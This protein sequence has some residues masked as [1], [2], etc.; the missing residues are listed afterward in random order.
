[1]ADP[2]KVVQLPSRDI[3]DIPRGL[4][5][6]ADEIE[7]G[8]YGDAHNLAWVIDCGDSRV[9]IGMLGQAAEPGAVGYYLFGLAMRKLEVANG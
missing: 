3:G 6:I 9:E 1:M 2:L 5:F 7:A 8:R 4:R